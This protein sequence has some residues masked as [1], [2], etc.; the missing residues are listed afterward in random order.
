MLKPRYARLLALLLLAAPFDTAE[1][2]AQQTQSE[3]IL[4]SWA[5]V[6]LKGVRDLAVGDIVEFTEDGEFISRFRK[7]LDGQD[8][9]HQHFYTTGRKLIIRSGQL[10]VDFRIEGNQL[11]LTTP[12]GFVRA[13]FRRAG[14]VIVG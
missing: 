4:G 12:D 8:Q 10:D 13:V 6:S 1:L 3:R 9:M 14:E 2:H 7:P 11:M 5:V